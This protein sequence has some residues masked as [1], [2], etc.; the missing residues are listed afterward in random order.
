MLTCANGTCAT[1]KQTT[2]G[3]AGRRAGGR[4]GVRASPP[5]YPGTSTDDGTDPSSSRRRR[6]AAYRGSVR[7]LD[8][9]PDFDSSRCSDVASVVRCRSTTIDNRVTHQRIVTLILLPK[10]SLRR[11]RQAAI[12]QSNGRERGATMRGRGVSENDGRTDRRSDVGDGGREEQGG[13][14]VRRDRLVGGSGRGRGGP[15]GWSS[16]RHRMMQ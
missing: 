5:S 9:P 14:A 10:V 7:S 1:I 13:R 6:R 3:Q 16:E 12:S 15:T 8:D 11:V 4:A 2:T